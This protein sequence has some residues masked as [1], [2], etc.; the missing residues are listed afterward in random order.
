MMVTQVASTQNLS[1]HQLASDIGGTCLELMMTY[2]NKISPHNPEN[3]NP[4][5]LEWLLLETWSSTTSTKLTRSCRETNYY[6]L[7]EGSLNLLMKWSKNGKDIE[8]HSW[9]GLSGKGL[10]T[11]YFNKFSC[12]RGP[13][14]WTKCGFLLWVVGNHHPCQK[15]CT[16]FPQIKLKIKWVKPPPSTSDLPR[17]ETSTGTFRVPM[18]V[19][20][21]LHPRK[22]T[23]QW[24]K[25]HLKMYLP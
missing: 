25:N 19:S 21:R 15:E 9:H 20:E 13:R 14:R 11:R 8:H 7:V 18:S 17:V 3:C 16:N 1:F 10:Y 2:D 23:W 5:L 22:L 12:E 6:Y 24:K 4:F